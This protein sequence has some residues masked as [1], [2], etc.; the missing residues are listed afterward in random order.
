VDGKLAT[1]NDWSAYGVFTVG[2]QVKD[3]KGMWISLE[4]NLASIPKLP[5]RFLKR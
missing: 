1:L 2:V 4:L 5:A 3:G